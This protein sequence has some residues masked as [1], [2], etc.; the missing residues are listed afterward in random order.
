MVLDA[1]VQVRLVVSGEY[2]DQAEALWA[3]ILGEARLCVVPAFGPAEVISSIRQMGRGGMLTADEEDAAVRDYVTRIRPGLT[4]IDSPALTLVAWEIARDLNERHT[5]DS[6]YL[7]VAR[8][9]DMG[10]W[11]ADQRLLRQLAGRFP[12]A[13][14]LGDYPLPPPAP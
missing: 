8:A 6:V 5:Y 7:A 10:F 4:V 11:T 2:E 13:H 14:F 12:E 9:F 3:Q 1:N